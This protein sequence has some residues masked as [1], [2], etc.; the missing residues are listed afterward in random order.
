MLDIPRDKPL[1]LSVF[2]V[3]LSTLP[4]SR[5]VNQKTV[6]DILR[7]SSVSETVRVVNPQE[8]VCLFLFCFF[9]FFFLCLPSSFPCFCLL[10]Q[11]FLSL[12][13][14]LSLSLPSL[15]LRFCLSVF[16]S[17]TLSICRF[18]YGKLLC[19]SYLRLVFLFLI[20]WKILFAPIV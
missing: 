3:H 13:L 12:S 6:S 4:F 20:R 19:W 16:L 14:S 5:A 10:F 17:V 15:P 11:S 18:H 2:S 1:L 8:S 7:F 9:S